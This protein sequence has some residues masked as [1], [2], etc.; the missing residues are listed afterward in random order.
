MDDDKVAQAINGDSME[1]A[2]AF[3]AQLMGNK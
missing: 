3:K 2:D 1:D